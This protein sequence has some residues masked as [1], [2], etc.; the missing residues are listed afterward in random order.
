MCAACWAHRIDNVLFRIAIENG[1]VIVTPLRHIAAEVIN[2]CRVCRERRGRRT[3]CEAIVIALDD[4][5]SRR[6]LITVII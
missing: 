1:V 5:G 3:R 2:A 4:Q 6:F